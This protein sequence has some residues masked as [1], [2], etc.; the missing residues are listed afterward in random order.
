MEMIKETFTTNGRI[1]RW[2]Y[3][4]YQ[5]FLWIASFIVNTFFDFLG[6]S[7]EKETILMLALVM[8]TLLLLIAFGSVMLSVRRLHDLDKRGWFIF[9][10]FVPAVNLIF[11]AYLFIA[12]GT[13]GNNRYGA[14][15]LEY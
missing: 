5:I 13:I 10:L 2:P 4:K 1:S 6:E 11:M 9:L 14:D 7:L 8:W 15:P 3:F 12:P